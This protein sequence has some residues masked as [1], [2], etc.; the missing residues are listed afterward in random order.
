MNQ[1]EFD[2]LLKKYL[3]GNCTEEEKI[4]IMTW[5]QNQGFELN[6]IE[7]IELNQIKNKIWS[8]LNI[9]KV[10]EKDNFLIFWAKRGI[11]ASIA[12]LLVSFS[13]FY[14]SKKSDLSYKNDSNGVEMTNNSS[15]TKQILL[16][17]GS[18]IDLAGKSSISYSENF[19]KV[20]REVFL[21]GEAFFN[22]KK[23]PQKPFIVH[24]GEL[25]TQVLGTS[26]RIKP[27]S[28]NGNIEVSV[29]TGRVSIYENKEFEKNKK[30]GIVLTPNQKII[31]NTNT[32]EITP[33]IVD[34]P[35]IL[36]NQFSKSDFV[37]EN[38]SVASVIDKLSQSFGIEIIIVNEEINQCYFTG[39]ISD[40]G[41]LTQIEILC[42]T[43]GINYE[44]RGAEI[45]IY[46]KGCN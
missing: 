8:N 42:K 37:F 32:K 27:N 5:Y 23:N 36:K 13:Y 11:A 18:I 41:L 22:I 26:F 46:G 25:V 17:D 4:M 30:N 33:S 14:F 7:E 20:N 28:K 43:L 9:N 31:Y 39:D 44:Q 24:S 6:G 35:R 38:E 3:S 40:M 15:E 21:K 1:H 34:E 16:E 2:L 12:I 29:N 19:G 10:E 45:F